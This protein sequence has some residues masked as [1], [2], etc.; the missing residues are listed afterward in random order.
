MSKCVFCHFKIGSG[1]IK[2]PNLYQVGDFVL[3]KKPPDTVHQRFHKL[4]PKYYPE[5]YRIVRRTETNAFLIPFT[6]EYFKTRLKHEGKIHKKLMCHGKGDET[7]TSYQSI[8]LMDLS[9]DEKNHFSIFL[10][11][12]RI[13][14]RYYTGRNFGTCSSGYYSRFYSGL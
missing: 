2:L 10:M 6:K 7:Q 8:G 11:F 9:I 12:A 3:L 13:Y 14:T 1:K 5:P 4:L